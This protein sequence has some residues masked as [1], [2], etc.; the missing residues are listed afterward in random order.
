[1]KHQRTRLVLLEDAVQH[2]CVDVDVQIERPAEPLKDGHR[3]PT[4]IGHIVQLC[5][6]TQPPQHRTHEDGDDRATQVVIPRQPVAQAIRQTQDPLPHGHVGKHVV[7]EMCGALGHSGA[8]ATRTEAAALARKGDQPIQA[9][10]RTAK[11]CKPAS[12]RPAAQEVPKLVLNEPGQALAIPQARGLCAKGLEARL[13]DRVEDVLG[14]TPGFIARGR[15]G[16]A[17][18]RGGERATKGAPKS[19]HLE[20]PR[21]RTP[22]FPPTPNATS[23]ADSQRGQTADA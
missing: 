15:E 11:P 19:R 17:P 10:G 6:T 23:S 3:T 16:H 21:P 13:H 14:R 1:M 22:R 18:E 20:T 2:E 5:T 4:T 8:S 7:H 9:A 12:Q